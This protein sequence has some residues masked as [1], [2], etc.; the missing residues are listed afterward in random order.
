MKTIRTFLAIVLCTLCVYVGFIIKNFPFINWNKEVKI[1]EVFQIGST[2]FIGIAIPFLVK[3]LLEDN[4]TIK[5]LIVDESKEIIDLT[6]KIKELLD[7]G[8]E[9][10]NISEEDKQYISLRFSELELAIISLEE[11][12]KLSFKEKYNDQYQN[13]KIAY[14]NFWKKI[15]DGELMSSSFSTLTNDYLQIYLDE[16]RKFVSEIRRFIISIQK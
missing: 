9:E 5:G 15:T 8:R 16:H 12:L 11:S 7:K 10:K 1:Y 6:E 3:K 13:L 4:K 14:F 2:L